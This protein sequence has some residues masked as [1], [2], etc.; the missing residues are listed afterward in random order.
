MTLEEVIIET[1]TTY[2]GIKATELVVRVFESLHKM[3]E[4]PSSGEEVIATI[5]ELVE[6]GD[7]LE[8]E[9]ILPTMTYRV[10]SFLLPKGT[11]IRPSEIQEA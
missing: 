10:K 9:Y 11:I 2:Q 4:I 7:L 5:N 8:I 3:P 6:L 1:V